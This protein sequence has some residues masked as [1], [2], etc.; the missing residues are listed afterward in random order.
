MIGEARIL[1]YSGPLLA[2]LK[3][4]SWM[5]QA[6]LYTI[7]LNVLTIPGGCRSKA[8][9]WAFWAPPLRCWPNGRLVR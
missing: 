9:R 5:K 3:W 2:L 7:F 6:I 8:R 1:E 4:A